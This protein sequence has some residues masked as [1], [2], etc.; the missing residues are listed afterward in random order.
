MYHIFYAKSN[1]TKGKSL[2]INKIKKYLY[3]V[4]LKNNYI[5]ISP[6]SSTSELTVYPLRDIIIKIMWGSLSNLK[7]HKSFVKI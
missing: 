5:G 3:I 4:E 2:Y 7:F 1:Q 6:L